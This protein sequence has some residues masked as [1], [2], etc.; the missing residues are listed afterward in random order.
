MSCYYKIRLKIKTVEGDSINSAVIKISLEN[1]REKSKD[2]E[3]FTKELHVYG[4]SEVT[5]LKIIKYIKII[6][7]QF[8]ENNDFTNLKSQNKF[9]KK[10]NKYIKINSSS[11]V[12]FISNHKTFRTYKE[13]LNRYNNFLFFSFSC[14]YEE[15]NDNI[16]TYIIEKYKIEQNESNMLEITHLYL[17]KFYD[18]FP[19]RMIIRKW[20]SIYYH[21]T[22]YIDNKIKIK[23]FMDYI[24]KINVIELINM[25]Y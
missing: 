25:S 12:L 11:A 21:D 16:N 19:D 14:I 9:I 10:I 24:K 2:K 8:F 18:N 3:L 23:W 7:I 15:K 6:A 20:R 17:N 5:F 1:K 13:F 22:E 4:I